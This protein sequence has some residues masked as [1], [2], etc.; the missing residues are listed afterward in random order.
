MQMKIGF[1]GITGVTV[2]NFYKQRLDSR[3]QHP[4]VKEAIKMIE[5]NKD[6]QELIGVP[7]SVVSSIR[8]QGMINEEATSFSFKVRGPRGDLNIEL[9]GISANLEQIGVTPEAKDY[10]LKKEKIEGKVTQNIVRHNLEELNYVDF[11]IPDMEQYTKLD[12]QQTGADFEQNSKQA[13]NIDYKLTPKSKFWKI[14]YLYANVDENMRIMM[15]PNKDQ[16][17]KLNNSSS[18]ILTRQTLQD[19]AE[20]KKQ[21]YKC[22]G[23]LKE[24]YTDV[25]LAELTKFRTQEVYKNIGYKRWYAIA[26]FSFVTMWAYSTLLINK[27]KPIVN[28]VL[29]HKVKDIVNGNG[30]IKK[31]MNGKILWI[32]TTRGALID[33][34]AEFEIKFYGHNNYGTVKVDSSFDEGLNDFKI[35][36]LKVELVSR[37]GEAMDL[38]L[39]DNYKDVVEGGGVNGLGKS[40]G[41]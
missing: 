14:D 3:F 16:R 40:L 23:I 38:S 1:L 35:Q 26:G 36:N 2:Y 25:E 34:R 4:M 21:R 6:V 33:Q 10:L 11:F 17:S 29:V 30:Q 19:L 39:V 28:S 20:E 5:S 22:L 41:L 32:D 27:R 13:E 24:S 7:V 8:N 31:L 37:S 15:M 18:F 9:A 12:Y